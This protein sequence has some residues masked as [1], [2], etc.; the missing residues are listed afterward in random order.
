MP[1]GSG[2][3]R[4]C[5]VDDWSDDPAWRARVPS[6]E[7]WLSTNHLMGAGYWVWLIPLG[8]GSTSFGIV[9][10]AD[11]HPFNR[12]NRFERAMDWLREFE[13]QCAKAVEAHA[14]GLEDF[15]ALAALRACLRASVFA[16]AL[17]D[18]RRGGS[19]HGSVLLARLGFHRHGQRRRDRPRR[20]RR[21]EA[22]TSRPGPRRSTPPICACS[23][24]SSGCTTASTA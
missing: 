14:D 13:P 3:I 12:L 4:G 9:A 2:S 17:G 20:P 11:L 7:R 10:D 21:A 5:G 22:R 19:L 24:H 18:G 8:S 16:R 15:L 6:G 1:P 23:T